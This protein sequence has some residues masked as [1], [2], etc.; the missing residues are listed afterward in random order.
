ME[1]LTVSDVL[2]HMATERGD[3]FKQLVSTSGT[4]KIPVCGKRTN[5]SLHIVLT[6]TTLTSKIF[7]PKP[8]PRTRK[9][10]ADKKVSF[11]EANMETLVNP[12]NQTIDEEKNNE[13]KSNDHFQHFGGTT[14]V[15]SLLMDMVRAEH[16]KSAE[17]ENISEPLEESVY[18]EEEEEKSPPAHGQYEDPRFDTSEDEIAEDSEATDTWV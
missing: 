9:S 15:F 8:K 16:N 4:H 3:L 11:I 1:M 14:D 6:V 10:A 5:V 18:D 7:A 12:V 13:H 17:E 2:L